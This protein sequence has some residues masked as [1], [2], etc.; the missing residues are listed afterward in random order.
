MIEDSQNQTSQQTCS[1]PEVQC[2]LLEHDPSLGF[3]RAIGVT[4]NEDFGAGFSGVLAG[5][6][7]GQAP[8]FA[9]LYWSVGIEGFWGGLLTVAGI[10][11]AMVGCM[12]GILLPILRPWEK[13]PK[14]P[15]LP[16]RVH[17]ETRE[18]GLHVGGYRC[19]PWGDIRN[20]EFIPDSE[21]TLIVHARPWSLMLQWDAEVMA[22]AIQ[23][24]V[25]QACG[26]DREFFR[27]LPFNRLWF[28]SWIIAGYVIA[29]A[30]TVLCLQENAKGFLGALVMVCVVG[31]LA[32]GLIWAI[33]LN[34]LSLAGGRRVRAYRVQDRVLYDEDGPLRIDLKSARYVQRRARG[35]FY[36]IDFVTI[37][38]PGARALHLIPA[39]RDAVS[40][41]ECLRGPTT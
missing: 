4:I 8:G 14:P 39:D 10:S 7:L 15:R 12:V 26:R 3:S 17:V 36:D 25:N 16:S 21:G 33:P 19:V 41:V 18:E 13:S 20:I 32:A 28:H 1:G 22:R 2:P 11:V 27:A 23:W 31:P 38:A 9:L 6:L 29:I 24:H 30:I 34:E 37:E 35:L 5:A 40:I